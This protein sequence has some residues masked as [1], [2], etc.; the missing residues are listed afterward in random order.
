MPP[1][2]TAKRVFC[3]ICTSEK[4]NAMA[5][6]GGKTAIG[7]RTHPNPEVLPD[8]DLDSDPDTHRFGSCDS[9]PDPDPD[10]T[11]IA[12]AV[13]YM[14]AC[15]M[16]CMLQGWLACTMEAIQEFRL[17]EDGH[18]LNASNLFIL[19]PSIN[20]FCLNTGKLSYKQPN[21]TLNSNV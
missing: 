8:P 17:E 2:A 9:D 1:A 5:D 16:T 10:M 11:P 18:V 12:L 19:G 4:G 15:R 13:R 20:N 21:L 14:V 6:S 3:I 7:S